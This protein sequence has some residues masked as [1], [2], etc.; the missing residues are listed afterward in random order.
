MV[1]HT[2]IIKKITQVLRVKST[3]KAPKCHIRKIY[4]RQKEDQRNK[5][6]R[7]QSVNPTEP[8]TV[9]NVYRYSI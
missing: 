3:L 1:I 7:R 6:D 9:S 4:L 5:K 2:A 8:T